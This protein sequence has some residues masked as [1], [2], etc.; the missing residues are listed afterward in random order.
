MKLGLVFEV[1]V[2]RLDDFFEFLAKPLVVKIDA[3]GA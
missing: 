3:Q 1:E 2:R